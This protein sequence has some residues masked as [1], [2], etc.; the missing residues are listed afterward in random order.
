MALAI[1][2]KRPTRPVTVGPA[3][4]SASRSFTIVAGSAIEAL[5]LLKDERGIRRGAIYEDESGNRIDEHLVCISM[6]MN[7][8]TQVPAGGSG[9]W[10]VDVE[11]G[12]VTLIEQRE[13]RADLTPRYWIES[14]EASVPVDIDRFGAPIVNAAGEPYDPPSTMTVFRS[15]LVIQWHRFAATTIELQLQKKVFEGKVNSS[16]YLG[17]PRRCLFCRPVMIDEVSSP[18]IDEVNVLFRL[19][20]RLDYLEPVTLPGGIVVPGFDEARIN[21]GRRIKVTRNGVD[22]Y[23]IIRENQSDPNSSPLST[24]V[25]LSIDGHS[26]LPPDAPPNYRI[27]E[28]YHEVD[29]AG[30]VP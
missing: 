18:S 28:K 30:L 9:L 14:A 29:F 3:G 2:E 16:P 15:T 7:P 12:H 1:I 5:Q 4:W 6:S 20:A 17:A 10:E 13:P 19:T 25:N 8:I 27:V 21:R 24:P 23:E 11:Y 26:V 22:Q